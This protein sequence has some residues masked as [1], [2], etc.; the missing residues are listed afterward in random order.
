MTP[1]K[2]G[3]AAVRPQSMTGRMR[4]NGGQRVARTVCD[5][6]NGT[7]DTVNGDDKSWVNNVEA[8]V[9]AVQ[10]G[11]HQGKQHETNGN[12]M[13]RK[14]DADEV[15]DDADDDDRDDEEED[16]RRPRLTKNPAAPTAR[17]R[18]EHNKTHLP[19][20]SWCTECV[21]GRGRNLPHRRADHREELGAALL[22][23][24]F[25]FLGE[26][27]C[28][29]T[30]PAVVMRDW[31]SKAI[32]A[33]LIPGKGSDHDW[34]A[35]QLVNDI[36]KLGYKDVVIR[37]DQEPAIMALVDKVAQ[38]RDEVT[39]KESSP[40]GD[41]QA[42][43]M[44][45]RGVQAV[46][47][48]VRVLKLALEKRLNAKIPVS[49]PI[50]AWLVPHAADMLSKLEVKANGR[51]AYEMYK[52][53]AYTG[54]L[55]EFG[56]K[57]LFRLPGKFRGGDLQPRWSTGIWLGKHWR[58][59]EH[60]IASPSDIVRARSIRGLPDRESW[61]IGEIEAIKA[62]PWNLKP[63]EEQTQ[64]KP[65]VIPAEP[66]APGEPEAARDD[67]NPPRAVPVRKAD[68]Q[69]WGY[70][71]GCRKCKAILMGD[72][73]QPTLGHSP[74]C[75]SRLLSEMEN[76]PTKKRKI[77][78]ALAR[79]VRFRAEREKPE[80]T[81][82]PRESSATEKM[83]SNGNNS[84]N[85]SS[86]SSSSAS[87][88]SNRNDSS[89]SGSDSRTSGTTT[90][91]TE[92]TAQYPC[93]KTQA[94]R[95]EADEHEEE[96]ARKKKRGAD[97]SQVEEEVLCLQRE[98]LN[99]LECGTDS[100]QITNRMLKIDVRQKW[101]KERHLCAVGEVPPHEEELYTPW[102][103]DDRTG[104]IL[105]PTKVKE[106]RRKEIATLEASKA[107]I[108]VPRDM[109]IQRGKKIIPTRW[110]DVNKAGNDEE[111]DIRSR[112]VAKEIARDARD[113]L[114]AGTPGLEAVRLLLS[115]LASSNGGAV[116][117]RRLMVLDIKRAFLN[118]NATRELYIELPEEALNEED[119]DAVG[120][121]QKSM[122][123]TRDAPMNW[124][125]CL[126]E[127]LLRLGFVCGRAHP[128]V[129][130]HPKGKMQVV[131]HV[132]DFACVGD[133]SS[134]AWLKQ[135]LGKSFEFTCRILG[136]GVDEAL[137]VTYLNR[138][139]TWTFTGI[140]Y[141]H[142]PK[143]IDV[144]KEEMGM[145]QAKGVDTPGVRH[146]ET[147]DELNSFEGLTGQSATRYRRVAAILNYAAQDRPDIGFA[148]KEVARGMARPTVR[149]EMAAK[150]IIRYLCKHPRAALQ[151]RWQDMPA[152][153]CVYSDSDWAGCVRTRRSTTGGVA[154]LGCHLVRS[155]SR[156][157]GGV[158]LSSAEGELNALTR[159]STEAL[160]L[161][162][163]AAELA[164][165]LGGR[166]LTDSSA[167]KAIVMR[168]GT[169]KVKHLRT[170]QLWVQEVAADGRLSFCKIPRAQNLADLMTHH[171]PAGA[172]DKMLADMSVRRESGCD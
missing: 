170:Q 110:L 67:A 41:S 144:V 23:V 143:H 114:F 74:A 164:T 112:C 148:V 77:E 106:A 5:S 22:G 21:K 140:T 39:I 28:D 57:V 96:P 44:A 65:R 125:V 19:F 133:H 76:D 117:N 75:R 124:Q 32:F 15:L 51:T 13:D 122:Y 83:N 91:A 116:P 48:Y 169:G 138:I 54:E 18:E 84:S 3:E 88:N 120:L 79:H 60:I 81:P 121:L 73:S 2:L 50:V 150:R 40:V 64:D 30:S 86:S 35:H 34:T 56:Q 161:I 85:S 72:R 155:W 141:E 4:G 127:T 142:D 90:A 71:E 6:R 14:T 99:L 172:G 58:S 93:T 24:D 27:G 129:F 162:T 167:A 156:T 47:E 108:K 16:V 123:G 37:S 166:I 165:V 53:R 70:T 132:D 153:I 97:Q 42:N 98:V 152:H 135:E 107:F 10:E 160:G 87:M 105:D 11:I 61:S 68:L 115:L 147:E 66:E 113:D 102:Y 157:Q 89:S 45:E 69:R 49:H 111:D 52:G 104:R 130:E 80:A 20:R 12:D 94:H 154:M 159:A 146:N 59:D 63:T 55:A 9:C 168:K 103:V 82:T 128:C 139:I 101:L 100:N 149:D 136:P 137:Q 36:K 31:S 8:K 62:T 109:A 131:V 7:E 163:L 92:Q 158:A 43:G 171:W 126:T 33:H 134:L 25:F 29:G 46:E 17:E 151:Y 78:E 119:G 95:R 118:A 1:L 38:L 26:P 145:R